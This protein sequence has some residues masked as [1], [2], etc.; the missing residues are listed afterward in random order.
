MSE[1]FGIALT[2]ATSS[3][4]AMN[5]RAGHWI[6][7]QATEAVNTAQS[8]RYAAR[9]SNL[10]SYRKKKRALATLSEVIVSLYDQ[11]PEVVATPLAEPHS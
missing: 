11:A 4:H 5:V 3:V 10:N 9:V 7:W 8:R 6:P 1:T 2:T